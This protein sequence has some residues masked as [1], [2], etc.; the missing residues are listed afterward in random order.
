MRHQTRPQAV[1]LTEQQI[2]DQNIQKAAAKYDLA[3]DLIRGVIRAESNFEVKAVSRAGAQGL[4]QLMPATAKE[5]G[6]ED[7]FDI[8]QNIDGGAKYLRQML[9]RFSGNVRKALAAYNA[10]PGTVIKYNGRVPYPETRRYVKR[11]LLFSRQIA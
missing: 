10:G 7:S 2:I 9:D 4:M 5:L 11:V 3:P 8:A 6:V 1:A